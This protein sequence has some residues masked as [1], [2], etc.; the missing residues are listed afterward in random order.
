MAQHGLPLT[1]ID[2]ARTFRGTHSF[3]P[4]C[5][6]RVD[7]RF[8]AKPE[9]FRRGLQKL[10]REPENVEVAMGIHLKNGFRNQ[11]FKTNIFF[12]KEF[13]VSFAWP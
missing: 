9:F 2:A 11:I 1:N 5:E 8:K 4:K 3:F 7:D 12:Q 6:R 10:P 13:P